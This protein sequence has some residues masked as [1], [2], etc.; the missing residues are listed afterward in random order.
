MGETTNSFRPRTSEDEGQPAAAT[1][2]QH[3]RNGAA[4]GGG[5]DGSLVDG[6]GGDGLVVWEGLVTD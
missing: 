2:N 4:T 1:M 3:A 5:L 6:T